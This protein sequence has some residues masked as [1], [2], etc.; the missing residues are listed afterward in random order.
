MSGSD[1]RHT[2]RFATSFDKLR[3]VLF[4]KPDPPGFISSR[5]ARTRF[6]QYKTPP[7]SSALFTSFDVIFDNEAR[8][9]E[10]RRGGCCS[11]RKACRQ[12]VRRSFRCPEQSRRQKKA[13]SSLRN[14]HESPWRVTR[15]SFHRRESGNPKT[16]CRI[17]IK[18]PFSTPGKPREAAQRT[19]ALQ[20]LEVFLVEKHTT[21]PHP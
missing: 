6:P 5:T 14:F 3:L 19:K 17:S 12:R 18:A 16:P 13:G 15:S 4:A 7:S 21:R 11:L 10:I 20:L 8:R 2:C 9:C 1:S